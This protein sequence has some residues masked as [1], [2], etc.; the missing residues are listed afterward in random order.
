MMEQLK[1]SVEQVSSTVIIDMHTRYVIG[2]S[3]KM[4]KAYDKAE[5]AYTKSSTAYLGANS[6]P[7]THNML[8]NVP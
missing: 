4:G 2:L 7:C 8:I 3:Y 1:P 5:H 6:Y